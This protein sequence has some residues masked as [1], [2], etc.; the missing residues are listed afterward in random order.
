MYNE[1]YVTRQ[2]KQKKY[3]MMHPHFLFVLSLL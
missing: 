1:T 3:Q 2:F